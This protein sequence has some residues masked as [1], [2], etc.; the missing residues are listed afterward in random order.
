MSIFEQNLRALE[1]AAPELTQKIRQYIALNKNNEKDESAVEKSLEGLA[2]NLRNAS[3]ICA[4]AEQVGGKKVLFAAR[5]E[6]EDGSPVENSVNYQ[7]DFLYPED[8]LLDRWNERLGGLY[9]SLYLFFGFG[10]GM[11]VRKLLQKHGEGIRI[12][13]YEPSIS[14]FITALSEFELCDIFRDSRFAILLS[15]FETPN[16]NLFYALAG[17]ITYEGFAG[18]RTLDYINYDR[19]FP[20]KFKY[21]LDTKESICDSVR[22]NRKAS[23]RFGRRFVENTF[24]NAPYYMHS[25]S[26]RSLQPYLPE[27]MPVIIVSSG[28]SLNK[29]IELLRKAK[30]KALIIAA[31]S[32]V[33][34]LL[35]SDILP[36]MYMCIDPKKHEKHFS[37]E[38]VKDIPVI[39]D[40]ETTPVAM[41]GH[42]APLFFTKVE[43][44]YVNAFAL[45][46]GIDLAEVNTGGSVANAI[47]SAA[48]EMGLRR[49]ILVGQDLAYTGNKSHAEGSLRAGWNM[50]LSI[51][52][53]MVEGM[54]GE[55]VASSSEF[56]LYRDW[57]E[58]MIAQYPQMQVINATEGGARI[59]GARE[60][61][62][63]DAIALWCTKDRDIQG[64]LAAAPN[65]MNAQT[66]KE[67]YEY[68]M[69]VP[70]YFEEMD[71]RLR[72]AVN[73]YGEMLRLVDQRNYQTPRFQ[74]LYEKVS[75]ANLYLEE[76]PCARYAESLVQSE[77]TKYMEQE[78]EEYDGEVEEMR[79][80]LQR[81]MDYLKLI[82]GAGTEAR[83]LIQGILNEEKNQF[84]AYILEAEGTSRACKVQL[85]WEKIEGVLDPMADYQVLTEF[86]DMYSPG[87]NSVFDGMDN[88]IEE[89]KKLIDELRRRKELLREDADVQRLV[90]G[91]VIDELT[92]GEDGLLKRAVE[93]CMAKVNA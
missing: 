63:E 67:F 11:F 32:A 48:M 33:S 37:D 19:L 66:A 58:R 60:M 92:K 61:S 25:H 91:G 82:R 74:K 5:T 83:E 39:C 15:E 38:R 81:G 6:N 7:L 10:N 73:T 53:V 52:A 85:L 22:S 79:A 56:V 44:V 86:L 1:A 41:R 89:K 12:F 45:L 70:S 80:A 26:I 24:H 69:K 30:G 14:I 59:H 43:D 72:S 76:L 31:D 46:H 8:A 28:P 27:E 42:R 9:N 16:D 4:G 13:V 18:L 75:D 68:M 57:F 23:E 40:I 29:N 49:V 47:F 20:E 35:R 62:L 50:D 34:V 65:I 88:A 90:L 93:E 77:I 78:A 87:M 64:I 71:E 55:M 36:D 51:N 17:R 54:N 84:D 3:G 2:G 21:Y